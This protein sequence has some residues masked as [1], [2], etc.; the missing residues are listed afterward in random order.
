MAVLY[1]N[2]FHLMIDK[3]ISGKELIERAVFSADKEGQ[4]ND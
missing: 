1:K 4:N 2:L 3:G